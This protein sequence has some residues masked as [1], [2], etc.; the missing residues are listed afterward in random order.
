MLTLE[1]TPAPP[2]RSSRRIL[3]YRLAKEVNGLYPI[4]PTITATIMTSTSPPPPATESDDDYI[5]E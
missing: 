3:G 1:E 4:L 5:Y 2:T